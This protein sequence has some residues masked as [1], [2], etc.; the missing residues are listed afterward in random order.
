M[1]SGRRI[2][3]LATLLGRP[4]Q[5][6]G[7]ADD[8]EQRRRD[9]TQNDRERTPKNQADGQNG[10][11]RHRDQPRPESRCQQRYLGPPRPVVRSHRAALDDSAAT[12]HPRT[13]HPAPPRHTSWTEGSTHPASSA[14][15]WTGRCYHAEHHMMVGLASQRGGPR[16]NFLARTPI[17]EP[18]IGG[19]SGLISAVSDFGECGVHSP[20]PHFSASL[21]AFF[22]L[23]SSFARS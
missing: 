9:Q 14:R 3:A 17:H 8:P 2:H 21:M 16:T 15:A 19:R 10:P 7:A 11:E 18:D 6:N 23:P 20:G 22:A 12:R 13:R 1:A 5:N 4:Y